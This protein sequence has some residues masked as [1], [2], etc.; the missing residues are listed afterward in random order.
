MGEITAWLPPKRTKWRKSLVISIQSYFAIAQSESWH[1][2]RIEQSFVAPAKREHNSPKVKKKKKKF[3]S[4]RTFFSSAFL[5]KHFVCL[6]D[7]NMLWKQFQSIAIIKIC[8][9]VGSLVSRCRLLRN[10][11]LSVWMVHAL[12]VTSIV[13]ILCPTTNLRSSTKVKAMKTREEEDEKVD[14]DD[15]KKE[16]EVP[17]EQ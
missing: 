2:R 3:P 14:S 5:L 11:L 12:Q 10:R 13:N 15:E 16:K 6:R 9:N 1:E 17:N 4:G 8:Q 7:G